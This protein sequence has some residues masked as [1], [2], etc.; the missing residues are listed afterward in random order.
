M[1]YDVYIKMDT[2]GTE[3][4]NIEDVGNY[5]SNMS[6]LWD[7]AM[8]HAGGPCLRD[9]AYDKTVPCHEAL[10]FLRKATEYLNDRS[11]WEDFKRYEPDNGWGSV[12]GSVTFFNEILSACERHPKAWLYISN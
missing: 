6:G 12:E 8:R 11:R 10:P 3:R 9:W 1:S 2:G 7:E 4:A 5:T